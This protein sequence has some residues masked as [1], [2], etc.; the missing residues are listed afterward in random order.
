MDDYAHLYGTHM[1][2]EEYERFCAGLREDLHRIGQMD[3]PERET[4]ELSKLFARLNGHTFS[5]G[6]PGASAR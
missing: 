3:D 4:V 5:D 6:T 2:E 1:T